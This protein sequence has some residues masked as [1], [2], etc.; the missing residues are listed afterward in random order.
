MSTKEKMKEIRE[1]LALSGWVITVKS[2]TTEAGLY[3]VQCQDDPLVLLS[4]GKHCTQEKVWF[5]IFRNTM[6]QEI[7][8]LRPLP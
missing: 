2:G 3:E 4:Q 8:N 6:E 1:I 7:L 5:S